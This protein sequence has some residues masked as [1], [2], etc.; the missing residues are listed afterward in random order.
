[1]ASDAYQWTCRYCGRP[2]TLTEHNY[3]FQASPIGVDVSEHGPKIS[4][5]YTAIACPNPT[6]KKLTLTMRLGT[7]GYSAS[8][9]AWQI[10]KVVQQWNLLPE[11]SAKPQPDYIPEPLRNDYI[12]ACRIAGLSPKASA[13]LSRRCLQGMIR[14]FW[15]TPKKPNLKQEIEAIQD[16]VDPG[17]WAAIDAVRRV[18]NI[19][20]HMEQDINVIVDVEPRE[21]ELLVGLVESLFREW[22]VGRHERDERM[23]ALV[24]LAADKDEDREG[25][26]TPNEEGEDTSMADGESA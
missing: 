7:G 16:K 3:T 26:G 10:N 2:T 15:K 13:T 6:C 1:M 4:L 25:E 22:Y 11:S 17:T 9:G 24:Q 18:G 12:E 20:A 8:G 19:G 14:D 21:A 5:G 23:R